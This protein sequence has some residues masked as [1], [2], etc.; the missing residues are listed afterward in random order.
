MTIADQPRTDS[1]MC[2]L[3]TPRRQQIRRQERYLAT[4]V[5]SFRVISLFLTIALPSARYEATSSRN[6]R[7]A[8]FCVP[9]H[10]IDFLESMN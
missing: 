9:T 6:A 2:Y 7:T 1:S 4:R 3:L 10:M 8:R 5:R